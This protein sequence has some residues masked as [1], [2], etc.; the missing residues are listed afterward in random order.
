M[1]Y[2]LS[3]GER[4]T[5]GTS[6]GSANQGS[7]LSVGVCWSKAPQSVKCSAGPCLRRRSIKKIRGLRDQ[8]PFLARS[9]SCDSDNC[10]KVSWASTARAEQTSRAMWWYRCWTTAE[11]SLNGDRDL[12]WAISPSVPLC[13]RCE[14][15]LGQDRPSL[16]LR[17][18]F[19]L[20]LSQSP[21]QSLMRLPHPVHRAHSLADASPRAPRRPRR[22]YSGGQRQFS[23]RIILPVEC[24]GLQQPVIMDLTCYLSI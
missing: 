3:E 9:Q 17:V 15:L 22:V 20:Y 5:W 14:T 11:G 19:G 13:Q 6:A 10:S 21:E 1:Y 7:V 24:S 16:M 2:S 23:V 4:G 18:T 8:P 12:A